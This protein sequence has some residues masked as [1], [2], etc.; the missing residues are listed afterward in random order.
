MSKKKNRRKRKSF[1]T[2]K[3]LLEEIKKLRETILEE[4]NFLARCILANMFVSLEYIDYLIK[5]AE[6][7]SELKNERNGV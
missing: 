1:T 6:R 5:Q 4:N 3:E 2:D 7:A